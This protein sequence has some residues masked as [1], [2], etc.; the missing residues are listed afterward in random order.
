M[1]I[2]PCYS[3]STSQNL[4]PMHIGMAL[5]SLRNSDFDAYSAICEVLDNSIEAESSEIKIKIDSAVPEGKRVPRPV[6]I[7]FGDDGEGM[8]T[9]TLQLCLKLGYSKRYDSR[10]GIGRFGVGM[11]FG[12]ISLCQKIEVYSRQKRGN[13]QYT[14]LDISNI[15]P[16]SEPT[17]HKIENKDLPKEFEELVGD[18]GTL[19]IWTKMDRVD[20]EFKIDKLRH[21]IGRIYRKSLGEEKIENKKIVKNKDQLKI[22]LNDEIVTSH[23][24]LYVT[25]NPKFPDDERASIEDDVTFDWNVHTVDAPTSGEKRG[26]ITIRTSLLPSSWRPKQGSGGSKENNK[27][28]VK[29]NEG[30]SILRNGREVFYDVIPNFKPV[31]EELDRFWGCEIDFDASLDHW[32]SVKNIKVGARPLKELREELQKRLQGSI[33]NNFRKKIRERFAKTNQEETKTNSGPLRGHKQTEHTLKDSVP[34][35]ISSIPKEEIEKNINEYAKQ[36][37]DSPEEQEEYKKELKDPETPYKIIEDCK[38]RSDGPFIDVLDNV[39]KKVVHYNMSHP[40]FLAIYNK[41]NDI[42]KIA[43]EN[44]P[45]NNELLK[46]AANLKSDLDNLVYAYAEGTYDLDDLTRLQKVGETIDEHM[47]KWSYHLRKIY[48]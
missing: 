7:A 24:P 19:V 20:H 6:V 23:D 38:A 16:E 8:D 43:E 28:K 34:P 45:E 31:T 2:Q 35:I 4:S 36:L 48:K 22:F 27:R 42:K 30:I 3:M 32:F 47:F 37:F 21:M 44:N 15:T 40:F 18:Y 12:A 17:I 13:W 33:I 46:I 41:I 11:T 5:K 39:G 29:E 10:K 25:K 14:F 26:K 9:E 1:N